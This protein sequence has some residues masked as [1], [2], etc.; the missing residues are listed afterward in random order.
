MEH[1]LAEVTSQVNNNLCI[2]TQVWE[3]GLSITITLQKNTKRTISV[4]SEDNVNQIQ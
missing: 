4:K 2:L 1:L 3:G